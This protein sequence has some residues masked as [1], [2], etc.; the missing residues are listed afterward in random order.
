MDPIRI[1]ERIATQLRTDISSNFKVGDKLP[2]V[3][4]LAKRFDVSKHSISCALDILARDGIVK[5]WQGSGVYVADQTAHQHVAVLLELDISLPDISIFWRQVAQQVRLGLRAKGFRTRLYAG[6][7]RPGSDMTKQPC[8]DLVEDVLADQVSGA[9][10][11]WGSVLPDWARHLQTHH[12][13]IVSSFREF[14]PSIEFDYELMV[15]EGVQRLIAAGRRDLALIEWTAPVHNTR[16]RSRLMQ[17]F[18]SELAN[19]GISYKEAWTR[20]DIH[21]VLDGA[22]WAEFREIW[23]A[24]DGKK[25]NG[26]LITDDILFRGAAQAIKELGIRVPDQLMVATHRNKGTLP[27]CEFPVDVAE[28]DPDEYAQVMVELMAQQLQKKTLGQPHTVLPLKW[29][30]PNEPVFSNSR[31]VEEI[32]HA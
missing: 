3:L 19:H 5:K 13:P 10:V 2:T 25:P 26:L 21:P 16:N 4:E 28:A 20:H 9:V 17:M 14:G 7:D 23:A 15:R 30:Q 31:T 32:L 1:P 24:V 8:A 12:H 6:H 18:A 11:V 27:P 22:G 29:H